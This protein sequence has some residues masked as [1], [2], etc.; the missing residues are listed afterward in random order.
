MRRIA[1]VCLGTL[2]LVAGCPSQQQI[3]SVV[4]ALAAGTYAG[5][6]TCTSSATG[7]TDNTT[8]PDMTVQVTDQMQTVRLGRALLPGGSTGH[9]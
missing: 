3:P 2:L 7:L 4:T 8:Q 5:T 6:V 9:V 1:A